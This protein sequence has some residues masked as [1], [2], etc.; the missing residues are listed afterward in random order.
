MPTQKETHQTSSS[1]NKKRLWTDE[2]LLAIDL[3]KC[4][5]EVYVDIDNYGENIYF[6]TSNVLYFRGIDP[7]ET[8]NME[9]DELL[10][11]GYETWYRFES[12]LEQ[13]GIMH[14]QMGDYEYVETSGGVFSKDDLE[15][16]FHNMDTIEK[17][18]YNSVEWEEEEYDEP[19]DDEEE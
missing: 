2:Q 16:M 18:D 11:H 17:L 8:S 7:S 15:F 12:R 13:I 3:S 10:L 14:D 6:R 19:Y 9:L 5:G 1:I 4:E